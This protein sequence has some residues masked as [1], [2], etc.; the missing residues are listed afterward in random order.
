M[1][2]QVYLG[3]WMTLQN[4]IYANTNLLQQQVCKVRN[5]FWLVLLHE[6]YR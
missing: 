6:F 1:S 4:R 2:M 3:Y 5:Y